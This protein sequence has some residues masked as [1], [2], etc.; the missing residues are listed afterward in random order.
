MSDAVG[1]PDVLDVVGYNY[2]ENR[3]AEDHR[4]HPKRVIYGSE[5]GHAYQAWLAVRDNPY[6]AGQFL[7]TGV[8]YLGEAN[9]WPNRANGAG[10]FDMCGFKKPL[11]WFRE[12]LWTDQPM[13]HLCA[14]A[15]GDRWIW[16]QTE[17]WNWPEGSV[18][19]VHCYANCPEVMLYLNGELVST[20]TAAET[21]NGVYVW[22][23]AY[24]PGTL[25]AVGR[26][27]GKTVCEH[28]LQTA[29]SP[30]RIALAPDTKTLHADGKDIAQVE[31][32]IVDDQGVRVPDAAPEVT[33]TVSGPATILGIGDGDLNNSETGQT[34]PHRAYQ[35][36]GLV[37][38]RTTKQSGD[39]T[40]QATAPGLLPA[41]VTWSIH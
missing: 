7:W 4:L 22:K 21:R 18:V 39:I 17:N 11:G 13:V 31:F 23:V 37:I 33:W 9:E 24:Q 5:N 41:Q 38:L 29:G 34:N 8:D 10:L 6:I 36:R 25:R 27:N 2:Q 40:L 35:G 1:L 19:V 30:S 32:Q 20:K 12:S 16:D 26:V 15:S 3:Y 28:T 14:S